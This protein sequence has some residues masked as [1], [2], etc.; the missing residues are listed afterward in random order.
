MDMEFK[1]PWWITG[2]A[3]SEGNFSINYAKSTDKV[4]FSYKVT[5][6]AH[7]LDV[8]VKL[9][10]YFSIGNIN[11]DNK[12][13]DACKFIV[14]N[15]DDLINTIIPHFDKYPLVGS[16]QLDFL[17]WKQAILTYVKNKEIKKCINY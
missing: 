4:T 2:I 1:S 13:N 10:N 6:K 14:S 8:L 12:Q 16:K 9:K 5:Q 17:D 11:W 15:T 7:S 3:D